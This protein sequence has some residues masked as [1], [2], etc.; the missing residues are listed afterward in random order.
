MNLKET[1]CERRLNSA[2]ADGD[3]W[4]DL[5]EHCNEHVGAIKRGEFLEWLKDY[6][7]LKITLLSQISF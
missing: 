4:L 3:K 6:M 2:G 1:V 7:L 5:L